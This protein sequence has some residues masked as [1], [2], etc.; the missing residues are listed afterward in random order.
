M[1]T[2][3]ARAHGG[4]GDVDGPGAVVV[5]VVRVLL[6]ALTALGVRRS[7][8]DGR[9]RR[10]ALLRV[11]NGCYLLLLYWRPLGL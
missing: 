8:R 5:V 2:L 6:A 4:L 10:I 3:H 1:S 9:V 11:L 7:G